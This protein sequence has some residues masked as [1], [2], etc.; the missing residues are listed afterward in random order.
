MSGITG[1][2]EYGAYSIV[3]SEGSNEYSDV[4]VDMGRKIIYSA[5]GGGE[6]KSDTPDG[7][8]RG[9]A[10]LSRSIKTEKPV[11]VLRG[12]TKWAGSPSCGYRY[13]G[14]YKVVKRETKK[15]ENEG[16]YFSFTLIRMEGQADIQTKIPDAEQ[17]HLEGKVSAGY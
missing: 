6:T 8:K 1:N 4:D 3:L 7:E 14:L 5:P 9:A 16:T 15:N 11:R 17:I 13:D 2:T 12:T 10:Y